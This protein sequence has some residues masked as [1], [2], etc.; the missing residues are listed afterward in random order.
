MICQHMKNDLDSHETSVR[1]D[2]TSLE[3]NLRSFAVFSAYK[4]DDCG[5]QL[6]ITLR[7]RW[8]YLEDSSDLEGI[9]SQTAFLSTQTL[10]PHR[11]R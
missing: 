2:E 10:N 3:L 11:E 7:A 4:S 8:Q 1:V 9:L 5:C 6:F